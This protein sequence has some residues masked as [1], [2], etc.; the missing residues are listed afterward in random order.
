[1]QWIISFN[2]PLE[3]ISNKHRKNFYEF[4]SWKNVV[5]FSRKFW[6]IDNMTL[7][8]NPNSDLS[9]I[10]LI[11]MVLRIWKMFPQSVPMNFKGVTMGRDIGDD[12]K[13]WHFS[14]FLTITSREHNFR[15]YKPDIR[16]LWLKLDLYANF[17]V[18][19]RGFDFFENFR[20]KKNHKK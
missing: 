13:K 16:F 18:N 7:V 15:I 11:F 6:K 19:L 5:F 20:P 2:L 8:N 9:N 10:F 12:R 17:Q 3:R 14:R 4:F 1:M